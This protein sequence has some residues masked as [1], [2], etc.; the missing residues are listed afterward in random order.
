MKLQKSESDIEWFMLVQELYSYTKPIRCVH[1]VFTSEMSAVQRWW[2]DW[3][4]W[5][6][7]LCIWFYGYMES[8]LFCLVSFHVRIVCLHY[9]SRKIWLYVAA[10]VELLMTMTL[11]TCVFATSPIQHPTTNSATRFMFNLS[12]TYVWNLRAGCCIQKCDA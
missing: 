10:Q 6:C 3:C 5:Q 9:F 12:L 8:L 2:A 7:S 11:F 4:C 1:D